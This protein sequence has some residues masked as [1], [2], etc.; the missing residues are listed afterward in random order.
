MSENIEKFKEVLGIPQQYNRCCAFMPRKKQ[1]CNEE[2]PLVS[3][4]KEDYLDSLVLEVFS[5][6]SPKQQESSGQ[7]TSLARALICGPSHELVVPYPNGALSQIDYLVWTDSCLF[8][9]KLPFEIRRL[10]LIHAFGERTL[11][12]DL[13]YYTYYAYATCSLSSD[14]LQCGQQ[15]HTLP[16]VGG[17][18]PFEHQG[19]TP[20]LTDYLK[21]Q[22]RWWNC[23]CHRHP[24]GKQHGS[25]GA[26]DGQLKAPWDDGCLVGSARHC[27][28]WDRAGRS[29]GIGVMGFLRSS[30]EAFVFLAN[31]R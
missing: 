4:T 10:I 6:S 16:V 28:E 17:C 21:N 25:M 24:P 3:P 22:W 23:D 18:G 31:W 13:Q 20:P 14:T 5:K 7:L 11:H 9:S 1:L 30:R 15:Q 12:M 27:T 29:C 26:R 8:F 19:R 2:I